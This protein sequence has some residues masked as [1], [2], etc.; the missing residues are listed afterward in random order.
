MSV[1][2]IIN[3]VPVIMTSKTKAKVATLS[4]IY[5]DRLFIKYI[6]Q[7]VNIINT[8]NVDNMMNGKFLSIFY[9]SNY[10]HL[11]LCPAQNIQH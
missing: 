5:W 6:K 11:W 10:K 1:G 7:T 2:L 9:K 8:T 3:K 4:S